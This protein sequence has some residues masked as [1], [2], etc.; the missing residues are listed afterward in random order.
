MCRCMMLP[1][2]SP[3]CGAGV[4]AAVSGTC[5]LDTT[6]GTEGLPY[7]EPALACIERARSQ[8]ERLINPYSF[9]SC[10]AQFS[11]THI[12]FQIT[13]LRQC[14][15]LLRSGLS[16]CMAATMPSGGIWAHQGMEKIRRSSICAAQ[17]ADFIQEIC[18]EH[19]HETSCIHARQELLL[20]NT[21]SVMC[22]VTC[23]QAPICLLS[24]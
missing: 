20:L 15:F 5:R 12:L 23:D 7:A 24:N 22:K 13:M 18:A 19:L 10:L 11:N 1:G 3:N 17:R 2:D 14:P 16:A 21:N 8:G 9:S 4:G 6:S